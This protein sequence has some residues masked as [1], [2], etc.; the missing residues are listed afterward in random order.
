M[1]HNTVNA[2]K[3]EIIRNEA[4]TKAYHI[5]YESCADTHPK[6]AWDMHS[7]CPYIDEDR[8]GSMNGQLAWAMLKES[9]DPSK[10]TRRDERLYEFLYAVFCDHPCHDGVT[11]D[12]FTAE[13]DA[14]LTNVLP[15]MERK[16]T[17]ESASI[18][19]I[20]HMPKSLSEAGQRIKTALKSEGNLE[21]QEVVLE[22]CQVAVDI[23]KRLTGLSTPIPTPISA[24]KL[25][26]AAKRGA[27]IEVLR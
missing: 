20:E 5:I 3:R 14:F 16:P 27:T 24:E 8:L 23:A 26:D 4:Q 22:R 10:R 18:E 9:L 19:I 1:Y 2:Q 17:A 15:Y 6:L 21:D 7:D 12:E 13:V 25:A 11:P